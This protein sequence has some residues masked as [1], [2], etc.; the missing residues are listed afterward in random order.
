M[1]RKVKFNINALYSRYHYVGSN[2][3]LTRFTFQG[4]CLSVRGL[5][6]STLRGTTDAIEN[7]PLRTEGDVNTKRDV[8]ASLGSILYLYN[9]EGPTEKKPYDCDDDRKRPSLPLPSRGPSV[10]WLLLQGSAPDGGQ[11]LA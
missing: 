2:F 5:L 1:S 3:K 10:T 9:E 6:L 4:E 8:V 7:A 11:W